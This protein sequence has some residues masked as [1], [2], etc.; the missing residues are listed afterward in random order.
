MSQ[1]ESTGLSTPFQLS[2]TEVVPAPEQEVSAKVILNATVSAREHR[3]DRL[4][5]RID[6]IQKAKYPPHAIR[7]VPETQERKHQQ[8]AY[9]KALRQLKCSASLTVDEQQFA[10]GLITVLQKADGHLLNN[11][12]SNCT[13]TLGELALTVE[14]VNDVLGT[15]EIAVRVEL[16]LAQEG[17][18][19]AEAEPFD[20]SLSVSHPRTA[21]VCISG[22]N[23]NT[24]PQA[25]SEIAQLVNDIYVMC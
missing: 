23:Q 11:L 14:A 6:A 12:L 15:L 25:V 8:T 18:N 19:I 13:L 3:Q 9:F 21:R 4:V 16:S 22:R 20:I 1:A 2:A 10:F 7:F 5:K 17:V 24:C